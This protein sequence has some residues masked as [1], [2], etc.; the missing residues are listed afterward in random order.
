M[1]VSSTTQGPP[2]D[3]DPEAYRTAAS[4]TLASMREAVSPAK[5]TYLSGLPDTQIRALEQQVADVI[6]AGNIVGLVMSGLVRLRGRTLPANQA[7][8]DISALFRGLEVLPRKLLPSTLYG[9]FIAAPATV[10]AAYQKILALTG[11]S[12]ESAFPN[13]LWQFYLEFAMREDSA[14][15]ANETTGF[16]QAL[17]DYN[18]HLSEVDQLAAWVCAVGQICFRYD[19]LLFNEWRE[20]TYLNLL[21]KTA[22]EAGLGDKIH[23][24]RLHRAWATQ[25]PYRRDQKA[26]PDE[27]YISYRRR[28]FD[29]FFYS[30]L[31]FLPEAEQKRLQEVYDARLAQEMPSFQEQMTLLAALQPERYRENRVPTA[32]WQARTG[33]ILGDRYYLLP[34]VQTDQ[35]GRPLLYASQEPAAVATSLHVDAKGRL[36]DSAGHLLRADRAG[37]LFFE[38]NGA[39]CGYLRPAQFQAVRRQIAAIFGHSQP[40]GASS[41]PTTPDLADQLVQISRSEHERVRKLIKDEAVQHELRALQVTPVLINWAEQAPEKPLATIRQGKRGLGDHPLTIFRTPG[42]MVFDQSHIFFDGILGIALS[43]I[44]TGEAIS[45][46]AYFNNLEAAEPAHETPYCLRLPPQPHLTALV[47]PA[48]E[49]SAEST[50]INVKSLYALLKLLPQRR[51]E[52]KLT[53][54]D[55]LIFYRGEFN[56]VYKPSV[57]LENALFEL[58]AQDTPAAEEAYRLI[59]EA[60]IKCQASNPSIMI[61]MDASATSPHERLYPTTFRNPF[62]DLWENYEKAKNTMHA[63]EASQTPGQWTIFTE[64]RNKLLVQFDYLGQLL[65]A[66]KKVAMAGGSLST[67]TLKLMAHIPHKMLKLLDEIPQRIDVLNELIKGEEVFSNVGRVARGASLSRFISAKDDNE[68]KLLVWGVITD[69]NDVMHLSLRDFRPHIASLAAQD[70]LDLAELM[71]EDYVTAFAAG[72]NQFVDSLLDILKAN[73]THKAGEGSE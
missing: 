21:E 34:L 2:S 32:L 72:F 47:Q 57:R 55:M 42:S 45:W 24:Q 69:D 52:L 6:P 33:I 38:E 31:Q 66:Y 65:R 17:R 27:D 67:A 25:R 37:R 44:L 39:L 14:R 62:T 7:Q 73:A 56:H 18:L 35:A 64:T 1:P 36:H 50:A 22:D 59:N 11:K 26:G 54:N 23:F 53:V 20:Q 61:P 40:A 9:T 29:H 41:S 4:A 5:L 43:E 58:Q 68:N 15:H 46:A 30:R 16:Q 28:R 3:F 19:D 12:L 48:V 63:Y 8:S 70:R 51:R 60:I 10:L 13:G 71:V 49:V